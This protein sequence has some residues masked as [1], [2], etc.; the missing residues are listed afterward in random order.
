[1]TA[2]SR[3]GPLASGV[4]GP[5]LVSTSLA[6]SSS[7]AERLYMVTRGH[8]VL[9]R[10]HQLLTIG[11]RMWSVG[12]SVF[13]SVFAVWSNVRIEVDSGTEVASCLPPPVSYL[14]TKLSL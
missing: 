5:G 7:S 10:G 13:C 12:E 4:R 14:Q 9:Y 11:H 1:M 3:L 2:F 6:Q 8:C